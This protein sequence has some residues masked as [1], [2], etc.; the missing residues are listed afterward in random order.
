[1]TIT[2]LLAGLAIA[3]SL[4]LLTSPAGAQSAGSPAP[5]DSLHDRVRQIIEDCDQ[6]RQ[7]E[8]GAIQDVESKLITLLKRS[9]FDPKAAVALEEL[10]TTS[11]QALDSPSAGALDLLAS[12]ND[13]SWLALLLSGTNRTTQPAGSKLLLAALQVRP[14]SAALWLEAANRT[15]RPD[16]KIALMEQGVSC[17]TPTGGAQLSPDLAGLAAAAALFE[18]KLE[19]NAGLLEKAEERLAELPEEVRAL[20]LSGAHGAVE[21]KIG[22]TRLQSEL[23]DFRLDVAWLHLATGDAAGAEPLLAGLA[24][25]GAPPPPPEGSEAGHESSPW[26]R[27][28]QAWRGPSSP[29]SPSAP[30]SP[31]EDPFAVITAV[32][33]D[34][35]VLAGGGDSL[36]NGR[37]IGAAAFARRERYPALAAY[38]ERAAARGLRAAMAQ[39]VLERAGADPPYPPAPIA[40]EVAALAAKIEAV[41]AELDEKARETEEET[42]AALGPDPAAP[43]VMRL[44]QA[45][46]LAP[47][48]EHPL[49]VGVAP[50]SEEESERRRTLALQGMVLPAGFAAVR[51]DRRGRRAAAIGQSRDYATAGDES[52]GAYWV[53]LSSDGG[54]TWS[55]PLYTGLQV[56]EP[57]LVRPASRLS[58][59][60]GDRLRIEVEIKESEQPPA[61]PE[62]EDPRSRWTPGNFYLEVPLAELTRDSDGD[63]LTD[64][65]EERLV[66]D[67]LAPDTDGDGVA[68]A[69][70][71]LPQVEAR[72][73]DSAAARALTAIVE[74]VGWPSATREATQFWIGD[75]PLFAG[76]RPSHRVVVLTREEAELAAAKLGTFRPIGLELLVLDRAERRAFAIFAVLDAHGSKL[77]RGTFSLTEVDGIWHVRK[78]DGQ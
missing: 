17:L 72:P 62:R 23:T 13:P 59:L 10:Y 67:P 26:E 22:A 40:R 54:A 2:R 12:A 58:L 29:A 8:L 32:V 57:Y 47:F 65:A 11:C 36:S 66:T 48:T 52:P 19:L 76:V 39:P 3:G 7:W 16:W 50:F 33:A 44:L 55:L 41:A 49:P 21:A 70:D 15:E 45:P 34:S 14:D 63:G 42:K 68:D 6:G 30:S 1:M 38:I 9:P 78:D 27:L 75:R 74:S 37:L 71:P 4:A 20:V 31:S 53:I 73:G 18:L 56:G 60:A 46:R 77:T 43:T 69:V 5:A 61:E 64:L 51:A 35:S 24:A 28:L 25:G